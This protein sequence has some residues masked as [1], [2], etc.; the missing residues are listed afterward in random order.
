M[1]AE[2]ERLGHELLLLMLNLSRMRDRDQVL[3]LFVE[4]LAS[5][6]LGI[7]VRRLAPGEASAGEVIEIA[8]PEASFGRIAL[9]D[10]AG[11]LN[12]DQRALY[13][14]ASRMLAVVLENISRAERLAS[15]NARLDA[16]VATRTAELRR[17]LE[18]SALTEERL[19]QS[20]KLEALGRL[21]GGVAHDFNNLLTVI[22]ACADELADELTLEEPFRREAAE[23]GEAGRRAAQ[24]TRQLLSFGRRNATRPELLDLGE[25]VAGMEKMLRRLIGEDVDLLVARGEALQPVQ[26]DPAQL[27]QV[28]LNL[29][30]NARDALAGRG[31]CIRVETANVDVEPD[32]GHWPGVPAGARVRLAVQDDGCGMSADVRDR[33]F[34]PFFTTKPEGKGTGLGLATVYGA[35][36]Q[37]EGEIRVESAPGLGSRFEV[38]F[39]LAHAAVVE[40]RGA[41]SGPQSSRGHETILV[42]E[43]DDSV[44]EVSAS[45]LR[46]AGYVVVEAN[47]GE[48]ALELV[49][50]LPRLDG[51]VADVVMPRLGGVPL[52]SRLRARCG[53]VAVVFM[54]GYTGDSFAAEGP[55]AADAT[56]LAKPFA[57][58]ELANAVR[59]ALDARAARARARAHT[60]ASSRGPRTAA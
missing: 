15:E 9:E 8:T 7:S 2:T 39:P 5:A 11:V 42:V 27:E 53:D 12:D 28:L 29:V 55:E 48:A 6:R 40:D 31:G 44:R 60:L 57:A 46:R 36:K 43:D 37:A 18:R 16:A 1:R 10:P 54:S 4:A 33:L 50:D 22:L 34:E 59:D 38:I 13:R 25:V 21:A 58:V 3:R 47:D 32:D 52:A 26:A 30:M 24:L 45:A 20:Q 19:R 35:V 14:N 17:A 51:L 49:A 41:C 56:L 23:I